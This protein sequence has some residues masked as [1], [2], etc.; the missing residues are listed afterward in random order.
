M[1]LRAG[2]ASALLLAGSG[3]LATAP[4]MAQAALVSEGDVIQGETR[5]FVLRSKKLGRDMRITVAAPSAGGEVFRRAYSRDV[6]LPAIYAL[7]NG[8]GIAGPI[9]QMMSNVG[10][11]SPAYVVS[12]DYVGIDMRETDFTFIAV[13]RDN[14]SFGDNGENLLAFLTEELR[15]F[16]AARYPID[17]SQSILFGHS[18]GGLFTATVLARKPEAFTGYIIGSAPLQFDPSVITGLAANTKRGAGKRVFIAAGD[19]EEPEVVED[20]AK[21]AAALSGPGSTFKVEKRLYPNEGHISFY[22]RWTPEAFAFVLP[23]PIRYDDG[24]KLTVGDMDRVTGVYRTPEGRL[25]TF[26]RDGEKLIA[27]MA[28]IPGQ[29]EIKAASVSKFFIQGYDSVIEFDLPATGPAT[30]AVMRFNG[31]EMRAARQ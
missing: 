21:M 19:K 27:R 25:F 28:G 6:K 23:V 2:I 31:V 17:P 26:L 5:Q 10:A 4:A 11:M 12:I 18:L 30:G 16:L 8:W 9:A 1:F 3:S 22:A 20:V 29:S 14:H 24:M 7:D 13:R 15:P